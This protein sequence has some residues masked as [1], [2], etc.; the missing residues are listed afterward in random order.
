MTSGEYCG[1]LG[2]NL[3]IDV[4]SAAFAIMKL[5]PKA[6]SI[7]GIGSADDDV[8]IASKYNDLVLYLRSRHRMKWMLLN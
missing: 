1:R 2:V 7:A 3:G 6:R 8:N 4:V 5:K